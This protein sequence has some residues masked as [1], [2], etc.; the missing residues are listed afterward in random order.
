MSSTR[1]SNQN[2]WWPPRSARQ[3][4]VLL[5]LGYFLCAGLAFYLQRQPGQSTSLWFAN[6][7]AITLLA[8]QPMRQWWAWLITAATAS[9]AA[10]LMFGDRTGASL[11]QVV[12]HLVEV[13]LGCSLLQ[14]YRV[15]LEAPQDPVQLWLTMLLGVIGPALVGATLGAVLVPAAWPQDQVSAWLAWFEGTVIG[16]AATLPLGL[17]LVQQGWRG[18]VE[19]A[20]PDQLV[21]WLVVL[22]AGVLVPMWLPF[23]FI[24][25]SVILVVLALRRGFGSTAVGVLL[26]SVAVGVLVGSG[27]FR[28][29]L[30]LNTHWQMLFYLPLFLTLMPPLLLA[31]ATDARREAMQR[32]SDN[33]GRFRALY[34]R[35]PAMMHSVGPDGRILSVSELWLKKLGY[36]EHEVLGRKLVDFLSA[37]SRRH[38]QDHVQPRFD[39]EGHCDN[40]P[41]QWLGQGGKTLDGL[42]S[43]IAERDVNGRL[44]RTMAVVEDVTERNRLA[45]ELAASELFEVTLHSIA[46][47]VITTDARGYIELINPVAE[48]MLGC[49]RAEARGQPFGQLVQI[50]DEISGDRIP[51][52]V[53]RCL[54]EQRQFGLQENALLRARDG[55]E[56]AIQDSVAPIR[57]KDGRMLGA[58]M[59]FQ[60][61]SESRAM[62][63]RMSHLSQHDPLTDLPN[64]M[65]LHDRIAQSCQRGQ[66]DEIRF[67]VMM[68]DL[69][70][71]KRIN[72]T[73]GHVAGDTLLRV[74]ASRLSHALRASDTVCRLGGD[75]F[76][77]LLGD[78][79]VGD[80]AADVAEKILR[81]VARPVELGSAVVDLSVSLGIATYPQDGSDPET[82]MRHAD[83]AMY[84]AK[85]EGRN[86]YRFFTRAMDDTAVQ[87]LAMEQDLRMALERDEFTLHFQPVVDVLRARVVAAEALV[88]WQRPGSGLVTPAQFIPT[89]EESR[90]IRPLGRWVLRQACEQHLRW[91][92]A[93]LDPVRMAVNV[94][95]VELEDPLFVS[96]LTQLLA[97]LGMDGV[98]LELEITEG[99]LM[100]ENTDTLDVLR[101]I[102]ALGVRIAVDDFGT[103]YTSLSHLKRLPIDTIKIDRSFVRELASTGPDHE[104]VKAI[105]TVG[106]GLGLRVVAEGVE[107]REQLDRLRDLGCV[108]LQGYLLARPAPA[109]LWRKLINAIVLPN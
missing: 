77:L 40:V 14:R 102:K 30:S 86:R 101:Q 91:R 104:I 12:P 88:R 65:L 62:T 5:G 79:P 63:A 99:T 41:T 26:V 73:L 3:G 70:H 89:A 64:R 20:S 74:V 80:D 60:D 33:E 9:L 22:A 59:V 47:G 2:P 34:R 43:A 94:S 67:A 61:V 23:P 78:M 82:L 75:E 52:P 108:E 71:F 98:F 54:D 39:R 35:T 19:L 32:L 53:R 97:E 92:D 6:G 29:P 69:D 11:V 103:G 51:D 4:L 72:D 50:F 15:H 1:W 57:G 36:Q 45:A 31:A 95:P 44:V 28:P 100:R 46:D 68:L 81:E 76:V 8:F 105:L 49:T 10:S 90:L 48:A 84:R 16:C 56:F 58:V 42:M 17:W 25:L 18:F 85:R 7:L 83:T 38:A 87:R 109:N 24:Y 96:N 106:Q 93:G 13:A 66:R 37:D 27:V 21:L 55:R 107:T